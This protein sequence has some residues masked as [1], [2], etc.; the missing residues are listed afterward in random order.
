MGGQREQTARLCPKTFGSWAVANA[1]LILQRF[2][3]LLIVDRGEQTALEYCR[4][5]V[6]PFASPDV[7]PPDQGTHLS[8]HKPESLPRAADPSVHHRQLAETRITDREGS[9]QDPHHR[10]SPQARDGC[11]CGTV[12]QATAT[13]PMFFPLA[14]GG[15]VAGRMFRLKTDGCRGPANTE[16]G[17]HR[18]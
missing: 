13:G 7:R 17:D 11:P 14:T 2:F 15:W 18:H 9:Q 10:W 3:E 12:Q 4:G 1:T 5:A 8:D 6:P 16:M